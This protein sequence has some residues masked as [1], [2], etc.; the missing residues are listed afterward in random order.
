MKT[1]SAFRYLTSPGEGQ[2]RGYSTAAL[3]RG[4][5]AHPCF[6]HLSAERVQE[7]WIGEDRR[8]VLDSPSW[9]RLYRGRKPLSGEVPAPV[10]IG[11]FGLHGQEAATAGHRLG[12][13][14][15]GERRISSDKASGTA[16][17]DRLPLE[18]LGFAPWGLAFSMTTELTAVKRKL[19]C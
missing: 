14:G 10:C 7:T 11:N 1:Q 2:L 17:T 9:L 6:E 18:A 12:L 15:E 13:F 4:P 3:C 19:P 16:T 8:G 5:A